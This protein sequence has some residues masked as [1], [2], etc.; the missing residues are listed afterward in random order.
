MNPEDEL[1]SA[2]GALE[3]GRKLLTAS[4]SRRVEK[5][6]S[7]R[8]S[9]L[10]DGYFVARVKEAEAEGL[11]SAEHEISVTAVG[12]YGRGRL[13][14]YSDIDV[15]VLVG[16]S[17]GCDLENFVSFLLYPLWDLKFDV[18][19]GVRS[20]RENISLSKKDFKVLTSLMDLRFVAGNSGPASELTD[21]LRT[22]ILPAEGRK[23]IKTLWK[24]RVESS[25][26]MDCVVLEP[27]IKDG[28]GGLRDVNFIYW[29][30]QVLGGWGPLSDDDIETVEKCQQYLHEVRSALHLTAGRKK[31]HLILE[32]LPEV[33]SLCGIR[34]YHPARRGEKLLSSLHKAMIS[35]RSIGDA[36]YREGMNFPSEVIDWDG[37]DGVEGAVKIF[38]SKSVSGLPLSRRARRKVAQIKADSPFDLQKVLPEFLEILKAPF[39]WKTSLEMLD[40]DL[41]SV[42]LPDFAKASELV[43][44]DGYHQYTPGRH[45]LLAVRK[46]LGIIDDEFSGTSGLTG[47][48]TD[49]LVLAA[50]LHDIA[51]GTADHSSEGAE[52]AAGI[53]DAGGFDGEDAADVIFLIREHLLLIH[54]SRRLD[55]GD[56]YSI[57][58]LAGKIAGLRR[59]KMLF[60]LTKADSMAT[61]P[62]AWNSWS[63]G[64]LRELYSRLYMLIE[65]RGIHSEDDIVRKRRSQVREFSSGFVDKAFIEKSLDSMPEKYLLAFNAEIITSHL[66]T[67]KEFN[68]ILAK[69]MIRKP[70]GR[71][72]LGVNLVR[73]CAKGQGWIQIAVAAMDQPLLFCT[74]AGVLSLHGLDVLSA[75]IFS[76]SDGTSLNVFTLREMKDNAFPDDIFERV[77][78][79]IHYAM[80]G[81]LALDY[82]LHKKRTSPLECV[83]GAKVP[84]VITLDNDSSENSTIVEV[85]TGDRTGLLYDISQVFC[86]MNAGIRMARVCTSGLKAFDAFHL[87]GADGR[88]IEDE[89]QL[90]ELVRALEFAVCPA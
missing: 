52:M 12:G 45:A 41:L 29:T 73:E 42:I 4:C 19:H 70:S 18:G 68:D 48:D 9:K 46:V 63:D 28:W 17:S 16:N 36:L 47:G 51:K 62:R 39:G 31:D 30:H 40:S 35:I 64:L 49:I 2:V 82:R 1:S 56:S 54:A 57:N 22:D 87:C 15:L 83:N 38:S 65:G 21:R 34:D 53:L 13:E 78:R 8:L 5:D 24:N 76:W 72:G 69:D 7:E 26:D 81:R 27:D 67:V 55:L 71:G 11:L 25:S 74:E 20:L 37:R 85:Q 23:L 50:L 58:E 90:E 44:F 14:P 75:E 80:T 32:L 6:F 59:L 60:V 89:G 79:S 43:P 86:R 3:A 88:K 61:G 84:T 77:Q 66:E 10:M 33:A